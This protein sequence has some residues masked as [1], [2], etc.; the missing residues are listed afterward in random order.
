MLL[1]YNNK[2]I[3]YT[4]EKTIRRGVKST[5]MASNEWLGALDLLSKAEKII[6]AMSLQTYTNHLI[7]YSMPLLLRA[8]EYFS[9]FSRCS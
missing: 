5:Y 1:I 2:T 7:R 6:A 9:A 4:L 8:L 3:L